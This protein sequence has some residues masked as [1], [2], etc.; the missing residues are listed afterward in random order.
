MALALCLA[1]GVVLPGCGGCNVLPQAKQAK[2]QKAKSKSKKKRVIKKAKPKPDFESLRFVT[3]PSQSGRSDVFV[4]PGHWTTGAMTLRANNFEFRGELASELTDTGGRPQ[5]LIDTRFLLRIE[6]PL[7][8]PKGQ[9]RSIELPVYL[10]AQSPLARTRLRVLNQRGSSV[11]EDMSPLVRMPKHQFFFVVLAGTVSRYQFLNHLPCILAPGP[12]WSDANLHRHYQVVMPSG[13]GRV[14]LPATSLEWTAIAYLLWDDFDPARLDH[15]QQTALLDWLHWGGQL[16]V[17]GPES[18]DR[19]RGSFLEPYLPTSGWES[20]PLPENA[21]A[22]LHE[23]RWRW[24]PPRLSM[25]RPWPAVRL[26][27]TPGAE[28]TLHT[29][30]GDPLLVEHRVGSGRVVVSAFRL[31]QRELAEWKQTDVLFNAF[32]LRRGPRQFQSL[33]E[34]TF[35][36]FWQGRDRWD[37][38]A[39]SR[40]SYF[41][42]D[43]ELVPGLF[44][45]EVYEEQPSLPEIQTAF[46]A[47]LGGDQSPPYGP[48]VASWNDFSAASK[49]AR[50]IV[51]EAAG[52]E[53]PRASFVLWFLGVYLAV[54]VGFNWMFFK[55]LGRVEWAWGAVPVVALLGGV[56]VI[57]LAQVNIGFDR[58]Q[59]ELDILEM[60]AGYPRAHLT[61]YLALYS[62]LG[63][64]YELRFDDPTALALPAARGAGRGR[65]VT[66]GTSEVVLR[67]AREAEQD[68]GVSEVRLTGLDV[69]SNSAELVHCEQMLELDGPLVLQQRADGS[70]RL[71][72]ETGLVLRG[73]GIVT[74]ERAAWLGTVRP[75]QIVEVALEPRDDLHELAGS[76]RSDAHPPGSQGKP[77]ASGQAVLGLWSEELEQH[78]ATQLTP[79]RGAL[80][81]RKLYLQAEKDVPDGEVRLIAWIDG[82]MPGMTVVPRARSRQICFVLARLR[83]AELAD[84]QPDGSSI[85]DVI[86]PEE[87]SP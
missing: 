55:L 36:V 27:P 34:R 65:A 67:R 58:S 13:K 43:S 37:P 5:P 15:G 21:L 11:L 78:E 64:R 76:G 26:E 79:P 40:L 77:A 39:V 4:K 32:L 46:D 28:A 7:V 23:E 75:G 69:F 83:P 12:E 56:A 85:P 86:V 2:G 54:L 70:L 53:V 16:L 63:T 80:N 6:R 18:L 68:R 8:L 51:A 10:P 82:G 57:R 52:I 74:A 84:P 33:D 44:E 35:A 41:S 61:R 30:Q 17:S 24:T 49:L 45:M 1:L 87:D 22:M 60:H 42:R 20:W 59:T 71:A 72:N 25:A 31:G 62:S 38:R 29:P 19:L 48:G 81:L 50:R 14:P 47:S 9:K 66:Q 3:H 73:A